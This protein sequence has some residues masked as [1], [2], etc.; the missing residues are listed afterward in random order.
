[1][2][3]VA[4][5][6]NYLNNTNL[7]REIM[8]SKEIQKKYPDKKPIECLTPDMMVMIQTLVS[9]YAMKSNWRDYTWLEDWKKEAELILYQNA[10]KFD[11]VK[12]TT[13][14]E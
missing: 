10:L 11:H 1:M 3:R 8:L 4:K 14:F 13:S 9:R 6:K 5:P 12:Y 2:G 7:L